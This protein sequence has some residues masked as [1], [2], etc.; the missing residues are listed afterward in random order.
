MLNP[1]E[2]SEGFNGSTCGNEELTRYRINLKEGTV[3]GST[4]PNGMNSVLA[5]YVNKFD[6]PTINE[7]YR[8]KEVCSAKN[9]VSE[10][11]F[12]NSI[13]HSI[14]SHTAGVPLITLELLW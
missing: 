7:A 8:G 14:A 5:R 2:I 10:S 9:I 11:V 1:P 12:E 6:F 3:E 13:I 4:F